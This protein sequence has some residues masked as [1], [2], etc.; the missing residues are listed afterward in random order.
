M[1]PEQQRATLEYVALEHLRF[2]PDNPRFPSP[3][4]G[5]SD[6][7]ALHWLLGSAN[8][9]D[10]M[11]SIAEQGFS[12][13]EPL[14]VVKDKFDDRI[15]T[16]VEGNR[17]FAASLLLNWPERAPIRERAVAALAREAIYRPSELP[18]LVFE[19][20][21][22]ILGFLGYR[23]ITGIQEWSPLAKAR[24]LRRLWEATDESSSATRRLQEAARR[25]G[26][27]SDY[28]AR[29]LT[30]LALFERLGGEGFF[31]ESELDEERLPF[32]LL[33]LSLNRAQI[34]T[35]LNL[36]SGQDFNLQ[37]LDQKRLDELAGW[38]FIQDETGRTT[39]GESRNISH[40]ARVLAD[41]EATATLRRTNSLSHA[42]ARTA[43]DVTVQERIS[44]INSLLDDVEDAIRVG[45]VSDA[46]L[47]LVSSLRGRLRSIQRDLD[48]ALDDA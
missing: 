5:R 41:S 4:Y 29:L 8:L 43:A 15:H 17:R 22:E 26:S 7:A 11:A 14:L 38:L 16:V 27:R 23:H 9:T 32:S 44:Q 1:E 42:L 20:S 48:D 33:V 34:V 37:G 2:D 46:D 39:L 30:A 24:Y 45:D 10:L 35:Y 12:P 6:E 19:S 31:E 18:C 36:S 13:G 21:D 28:V 3:E 25:I 40:L 47:A